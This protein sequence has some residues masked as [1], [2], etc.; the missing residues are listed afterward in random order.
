[1]QPQESAIQG[2]SARPPT[3]VPWWLVRIE[4]VFAIDQGLLLFAVPGGIVAVVQA[5]RIK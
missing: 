2:A 4:G 3:E 5:F 1:M